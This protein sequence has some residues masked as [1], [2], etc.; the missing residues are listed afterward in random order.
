[1]GSTADGHGLSFGVKK[2]SKIRQSDGCPPL[3][4]TKTHS[5]IYFN[6]GIVCELCQ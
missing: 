2:C 1:M 6:G 3:E 5:M 4:Y